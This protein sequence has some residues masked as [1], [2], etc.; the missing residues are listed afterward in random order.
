VTDF[1]NV[2]IHGDSRDYLPRIHTPINCLLTDPPY[3]MAFKSN[4]AQTPLGKKYTTALDNDNDLDAALEL[5]NDIM[6]VGVIPNLADQAELY[7]FTAWHVLDAWMPLMRSY[8]SDGIEL[9]QMLVWDKG[10]PG[11]GDLDGNWGCGH[12]VI[13]Y[14]KKGRRPIPKRRS[15]IIHVDKIP[16]G[17][18]IHPTEKPVALLKQLLEM[19]TAPGDLVVD[20][21]S[22]SGSTSV[23]AMELARNSLAF[24]IDEQYIAPSRSRLDRIGFQFD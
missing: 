19:S 23:A 24:E 5:F 14:L 13:L 15:G 7:V 10:Y 3:G 11:M 20:P 21:F 22:G 6:R 16:S 4:R 2:I 18:N 17:Q 12:E 9:K 8:K 1:K